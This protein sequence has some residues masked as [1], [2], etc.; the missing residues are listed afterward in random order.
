MTHKKRSQKIPEPKFITDDGC[1][2]FDSLFFTSQDTIGIV[3]CQHPSL[4]VQA[5]IGCCYQGQE[6]RQDEIKIA[7]WGVQFPN[8]AAAQLFPQLQSILD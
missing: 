7:N 3:I 6:Q 2:I 8:K 4:N 5:Y 1:K